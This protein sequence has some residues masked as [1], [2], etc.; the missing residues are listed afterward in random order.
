MCRRCGSP[1]AQRWRPRPPTEATP[2][3]CLT[4]PPPPRLSFS[5][6]AACLQGPR[7]RRWPL[8]I[9]AAPRP[10]SLCGNWCDTAGGGRRRDEAL[11]G[12][13][14]QSATSRYHPLRSV[15]DAALSSCKARRSDLGAESARGESVLRS[16]PIWLGKVIL[17]G[18]DSTRLQPR[19]CAR[20]AARCCLDIKS[21]TDHII[22]Y[23][24]TIGGAD[25][26]RRKT[27]GRRST[28]RRQERTDTR[29]G[30]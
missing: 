29:G 3:R 15:D 9:S 27:R 8:S 6:A 16:L 11:P 13:F 14:R 18:A 30:S 26:A 25:D 19:N 22:N 20:N 12:E 7:F 2:A 24:M 5:P 1:P 21:S 4:R 28:T 23:A 17:G 10:A